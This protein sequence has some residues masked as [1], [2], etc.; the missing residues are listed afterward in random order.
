MGLAPFRSSSVSSLSATIKAALGLSILGGV[1]LPADAGQYE[2]LCGGSKC[3]II[4]SPTE[5]SSLYGRIPS[6]RVSYWSNSGESKTSVGAGVATTILF[7]GVGLLGFLAKNHQ[8]KFI[9]NG[10]D[11]SGKAVAMQFE[12][13]NDKPA[14][15]LVQEMVAVTGLG[16]GQSRTIDEIKAAENSD[17]QGLGEMPKQSTGLESGTLKPAN[18]SSPAKAS[19]N[20]WS[21]YLNNNPAMKKWSESNPTLAEQNKKR[22]DD[23]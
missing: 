2:A 5:I 15:L 10:F 4:V 17:Q 12:F 22:F 7:G 23:C 9:V 16:M 3:T 14:K 1:W 8:Y 20:C 11:A 6:R 13:K 19:K 21:S 18:T